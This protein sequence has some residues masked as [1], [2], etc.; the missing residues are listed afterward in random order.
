M[1]ANHNNFIMNWSANKCKWIQKTGTSQQAKCSQHLN[2]SNPHFSNHRCHPTV[3]PSVTTNLYIS[4]IE[5]DVINCYACYIIMRSPTQCANMKIMTYKQNTHNEFEICVCREAEKWLFFLCV[6]LLFIRIAR[7]EQGW[8]HTR[9]LP[10]LFHHC[11]GST[12][13]AI[14]VLFYGFRIII[15]IFIIDD[16]RVYSCYIRH[17]RN[18]IRSLLCSASIANIII[19]CAFLIHSMWRILEKTCEANGKNVLIYMNVL[20]IFN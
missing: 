20:D 1:N 3:A 14:G 6:C 2:Q 17:E 11:H 15:C 9:S 7:T 8:F 18:I 19:I 16:I 13:P 10:L 4:P 5:I 12:E